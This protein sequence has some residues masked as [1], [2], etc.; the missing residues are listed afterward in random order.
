MARH[1]ADLQMNRSN[2]WRCR[3]RMLVPR[4]EHG[5]LAVL[6]PARAYPVDR[7]LRRSCSAPSARHAGWCFGPGPLFSS[8]GAACS[9][10]RCWR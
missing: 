6:G 5:A 2:R 1:Q 9:D 7:T 10:Q 4:R 8:G 3:R